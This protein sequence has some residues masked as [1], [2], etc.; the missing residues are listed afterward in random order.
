MKSSVSFSLALLV[1]GSVLAQNADPAARALQPAPVPAPPAAVPG[2]ESPEP[3]PTPGKN[4]YG[5]GIART[6]KNNRRTEVIVSETIKGG[7]AGVAELNLD[8]ANQLMRTIQL[9]DDDS[10]LPR[11]TR[12]GRTLI[13]QSTDRDPAALANAEE[14]LSVMALI[15]R[16]ATGVARTEERRVAMGIEVDS[17]VF[18]SSSGARNIYLEGYGALFLLGVRYPLIAPTDAIKENA[19]KENTTN[20]WTSARD[21][22]LNN[23]PARV[24]VALDR[25][26]TTQLR[27]A[28]EQY[29]SNKVEEL[30]TALFQ[31]L[32][33]A[34]HIRILKPTDFV[35][36]VIQGGEVARTEK[37]AGRAGG[38]GNRI[39]TRA[40]ET[41]MTMRVRASDA[42]AFGKGELDLNGLR[43]RTVIQTYFRRGDSS[44]GTAGF[45]APTP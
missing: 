28:A 27:Q 17:S 25:I 4:P 45:M 30:K 35:T 10:P 14:D 7:G 19:P 1:T 8:K 42:L 39:E 2:P 38:K 23:G 3:L 40:A 34:A 24:Q 32:K 33:N 11:T 36:I 21:E 41:V 20:E 15:L 12:T 18:G 29:D 16:K 6:N 13:I 37:T 5:L 43:Q 9:L 44:V 26:W 31:A 22:F